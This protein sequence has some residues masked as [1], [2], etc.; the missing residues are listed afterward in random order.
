MFHGYFGRVHNLLYLVVTYRVIKIVNNLQ[1]MLVAVL[2]PWQ[3]RG[4]KNTPRKTNTKADFIKDFK[5]A[6]YLIEEAS[7]L[8][9]YEDEKNPTYGIKYRCEKFLKK[10]KKRW[11]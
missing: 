9:D 2:S 4:M 8:L 1:K 11:M 5:E 3:S 10:V 6:F 7:S